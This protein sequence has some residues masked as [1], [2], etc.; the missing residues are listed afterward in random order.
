MARIKVESTAYHPSGTGRNYLRSGCASF[1][2]SVYLK[3]L[4]YY[5]HSLQ[6]GKK[7]KRK[8][9]EYFFSKTNVK[10]IILKGP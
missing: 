6:K 2:F 8:I 4:D 1:H 3:I 10:E 5:I 7:M 9:K